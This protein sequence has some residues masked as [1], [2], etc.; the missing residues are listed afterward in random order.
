M[1]SASQ[2]RER[3]RLGAVASATCAVLAVAAIELACAEECDAIPIEPGDYV[4]TDDP[5]GTLADANLTVGSELVTIEY[6]E[7]G[8]TYL[9]E[10]RRSAPE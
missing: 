2:R 10:F 1:R 8:V 7:A 5:Q 9:V 4:A 3:W 6:R